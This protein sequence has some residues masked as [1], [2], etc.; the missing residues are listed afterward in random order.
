MERAKKFCPHLWDNED[1]N[2]WLR[3]AFLK[4]PLLLKSMLN[5][6]FYL[7]PSSPFKDKKQS[8][9]RWDNFS[10]HQVYKKRLKMNQG[11]NHHVQISKELNFS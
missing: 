5:I 6:S 9:L 1:W 10:S 4:P 11:P 7:L 3:E 8:E 2:K